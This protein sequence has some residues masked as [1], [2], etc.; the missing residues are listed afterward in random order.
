MKRDY[1]LT[2]DE[3]GRAIAHRAD[4][5]AA[6]QAAA[7]GE[8]VISMFDCKHP[9]PSYLPWHSCLTGDSGRKPATRRS[10]AP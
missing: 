10:P 9:L 3:R 1:A 4:C 6:R 8:P 7:R 2:A 5:P